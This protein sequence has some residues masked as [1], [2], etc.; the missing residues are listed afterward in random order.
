MGKNGR[1]SHYVSMGRDMPT[2]GAFIFSLY[3]VKLDIVWFLLYLIK[4]QIRR[5]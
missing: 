4:G 3:I 5:F 1:G 2:K